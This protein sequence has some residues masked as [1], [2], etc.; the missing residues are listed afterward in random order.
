M[1]NPITKKRSEVLNNWIVIMEFNA[2]K[3]VEL[4]ADKKIMAEIISKSTNKARLV[5]KVA[6]QGSFDKVLY[7]KIILSIARRYPENEDFRII[8]EL[9]NAY[10]YAHDLRP[11]VSSSIIEKV[12]DDLDN[13]CRTNTELSKIFKVIESKWLRGTTFPNIGLER[14]KRGAPRQKLVRG[15]IFKING[16]F[17][18]D[19]PKTAYPKIA[20]FVNAVFRKEIIDPEKAKRRI[21]QRLNDM[22]KNANVPEN[23]NIDEYLEKEEWTNLWK[24]D[25]KK[26]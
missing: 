11:Y 19:I 6:Y 21:D 2:K 22:Y 15:L 25:I 20:R 3:L 10:K 7:P 16:A 9:E 23:D 13:Y 4:G 24:D 8:T 1:T 5:Q 26:K 18:K 12:L 17:D 14:G